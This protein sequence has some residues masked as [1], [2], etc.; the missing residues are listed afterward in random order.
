MTANQ[1]AYAKH[2]EDV[3]HN[4]VSE[5]HE[6]RDV[7]S[8]ELQ[9]KSAWSQ[10]GTAQIRAEEDARHNRETESAQWWMNRATITEQQRANQEKERIS[11][12]DAMSND[13][14][15]RSTAQAQHRTVDVAE[16][17]ALTA[18]HKL[19]VDELNARTAAYKAE[20]T[21]RTADAQA[22]AN[23][24]RSAELAET[25][26][27][28]KAWLGFNYANLSETGRTHRANESI[29]SA[30]NAAVT[31]ESRRHNVES[32]KVAT[33]QAISAAKQA[34]AATQNAY[35]NSRNAS[36]NQQNANT[37]E[38]ELEVQ[39]KNATSNRINAVANAGRT[40]ISGVR[41]FSG[42]AASII[43]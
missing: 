7:Q 43:R 18:W 8:R 5:R 17:N 38:A 24:I 20:Q 34:A 16:R 10:A 29:Q 4:R 15:R 23:E 21:A 27:Q 26:R 19:G 31:A 28:N 13:A 41:S 36:S 35:T 42:L 37:R 22:R 3:R 6:H 2:R 39:R 30:Y 14:Y 33:S 9:A 12:Y 11:W 1:I 32:E 40:V 25:I